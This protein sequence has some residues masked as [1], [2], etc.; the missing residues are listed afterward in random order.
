MAKRQ[1]RFSAPRQRG[2]GHFS[3]PTKLNKGIEG[4]NLADKPGK[5]IMND[6]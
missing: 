3:A 1:D 5:E 4:D 6:R 2:D